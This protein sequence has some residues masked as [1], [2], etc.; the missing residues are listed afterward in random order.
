MPGKPEKYVEGPE[1]ETIYALGG[2]CEVDRIEEI[3]YLNQ[4][5]QFDDMTLWSV[6]RERQPAPIA[7][8]R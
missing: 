5:T 3:M 7:E 6:L 2:L 4:L 8:T 1:Y